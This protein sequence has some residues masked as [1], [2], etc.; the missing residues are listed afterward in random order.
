MPGGSARANRS[1]SCRWTPSLDPRSDARGRLD[2]IDR[3]VIDT[4]GFR[5]SHGLEIHDPDFLPGGAKY[6]DLPALLALGAPGKLWLSGETS[7][8]LELVRAQYRMS[9]AEKALETF[10]G[11]PE[12]VCSTALHWLLSAPGL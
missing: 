2:A 9:G 10:T 7:Q 8:A 4:A 5:F 11:R 3:A 6:G 12:Q 1:P